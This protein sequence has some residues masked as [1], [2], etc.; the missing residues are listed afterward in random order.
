[1]KYWN[2]NLIKPKLNYEFI[3]NIDHFCF[4]GRVH[5]A[6]TQIYNAWPSMELAQRSS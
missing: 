2:Q 3:D 1:M 6:Y 4:N 5:M